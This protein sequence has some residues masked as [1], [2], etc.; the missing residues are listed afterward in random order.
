[1]ITP[2]PSDFG[3]AGIARAGSHPLSGIV[4][5]TDNLVENAHPFLSALNAWTSIDISCKV[6]LASISKILSS[7]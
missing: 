2:G 4:T 5:A 6:H 1:M 3:V 7:L